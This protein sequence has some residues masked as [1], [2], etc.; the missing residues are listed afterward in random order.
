[1]QK[2][3]AVTLGLHIFEVEITTRCNLNCTHCYNRTS[4][5]I[6]MPLKE[7]IRLL[8]LAESHGVSRFVISGGE[9]VM[10]PDFDALIKFLAGFKRNM[11]V[12]IQ[13]N[14][15]IGDFAGSLKGAIDIVHLSFEPDY[16]NVRDSSVEKIIS[17]AKKF[18][19]FGIY[20]YFFATVHPENIQHIDWM[21]DVA[22]KSKIDIG[23]N[24]CIA[25][26]R[27]SLQ[28]SLEQ[29]LFA[30]TKLNQLSE[31]KK[32]LRFTS[33]YSA[34]LQNKESDS[35]IGNRGGCT[36]G[37]AAC[38][39]FPNGDVAPC[40]F[41]R[42]KAGNIYEQDFETIWF[43]SDIF[44]A[45]RDRSL[46]DEPCGTCKHLSY[47]GGCRASAYNKN[48]IKGADPCCIIV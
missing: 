47:C 45:L 11:K 46:F 42:I 20:T 33:T 37:I 12:I 32:T 43:N 10:H 6:D 29:R 9:A 48:G 35:Y 2:I 3:D 27:D 26:N 40:P 36:A 41:F 22:N 23:F 7:I 14:G 16:S 34:I 24:L 15:L 19:D 44:T 17:I 31:Q 28:L 38:V 4:S 18:I 5:I 13:S 25:N 39:I 1:M 8:K 21:V 30:I